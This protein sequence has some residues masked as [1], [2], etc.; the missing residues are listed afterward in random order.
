LEI[1][2]CFWIYFSPDSSST[3]NGVASYQP[4]EGESGALVGIGLRCQLPLPQTL[5]TPNFR[6]NYPLLSYAKTLRAQR[7]FAK[8]FSLALSAPDALHPPLQETL[9]RVSNAH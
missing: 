7:F 5:R 9:M 3:T 8:I 1:Y 6:V 2:S 4:H